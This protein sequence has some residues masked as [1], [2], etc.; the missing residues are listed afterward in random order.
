LKVTFLTKQKDDDYS[1]DIFEMVAIT[2]EP[3]KELVKGRG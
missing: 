2:H 3:T 1:L